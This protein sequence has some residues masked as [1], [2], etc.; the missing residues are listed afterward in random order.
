MHP[1]GSG[2][3]DPFSRPTLPKALH[4]P[5]PLPVLIA[6]VRRA[7]KQN[8]SQQTNQLRHAT[9]KTINNKFLA[10]KGGG[11]LKL[12]KKKLMLIATGVALGGGPNFGTAPPL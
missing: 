12:N 2:T 9:M 8:F 4:S 10:A 5:S 6:A 3:L 7:R 11:L 1:S